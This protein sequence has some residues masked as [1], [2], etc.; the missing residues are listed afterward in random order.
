MELEKG[1]QGE[2]T[3]WVDGVFQGF[4]SDLGGGRGLFLLAVTA[5]GDAFGIL[6]P[7]QAVDLPVLGC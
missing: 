5:G 6:G 1:S 2:A 4:L 3:S 7:I